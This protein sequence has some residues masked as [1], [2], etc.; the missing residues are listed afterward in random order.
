MVSVWQLTEEIDV[1]RNGMLAQKNKMAVVLEILGKEM[2]DL[3]VTA[4]APSQ[5]HG[6]LFSD[7]Q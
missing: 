7:C 4:Q 6:C 3:K 1:L 5:P 2:D